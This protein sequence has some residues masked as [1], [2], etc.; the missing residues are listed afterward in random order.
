MAINWRE[1][2][3]IQQARAAR[4]QLPRYLKLDG[5]RYL[6]AAALFLALISLLSLGQTGRLATRG[7]ELGRLQAQKNQ[8]LRQQSA[9]NL[10]LSEAQSLIKIQQRAIDMKL[11]PMTPDQVRYVTV[12]ADGQGSG[13]ENQGSVDKEPAVEDRQQET[14]NQ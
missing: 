6:I 7:Y 13:V 5:G 11:R 4:L 14:G 10:Q 12:Q 9:L 1:R 3:P 2:L 8:L